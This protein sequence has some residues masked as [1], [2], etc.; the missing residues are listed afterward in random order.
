MKRL[1]IAVA[2]GSLVACS[3]GGNPTAPTPAS[4]ANMGGSVRTPQPTSPAPPTS[5]TCDAT[6]VQFAYGQRMSAELVES[7]RVAA[8]ARVARVIRPN[9]AITTDSMPGRLNLF[10]NAQD[11]VQSAYCG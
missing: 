11:I 6:K 1:A 3:G 8:C 2:I 10:V 5:P 9:D 7:A 4:N